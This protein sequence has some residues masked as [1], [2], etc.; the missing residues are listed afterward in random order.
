VIIM[1]VPEFPPITINGVRL[2][3]AQAMTIHVAVQSFATTLQEEGL[4]DDAMGKS[5]TANYLAR[6]REINRLL[7]PPVSRRTYNVYM[8]VGEPLPAARMVRPAEGR[9]A[10]VYHIDL[11][12][13]ELLALSDS[14]DVMLTGTDDEGHQRLALDEKGK[15]FRQR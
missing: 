11:S 3:E 2:T 14:Y 8:W 5:L 6:I 10:P 7:V 13:A 12:D 9:L 15:R 1:S 4:G